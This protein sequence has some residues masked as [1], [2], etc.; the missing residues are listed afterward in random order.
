MEKCVICI[1]EKNMR[2]GS[3]QRKKD[4]E[5]KRKKEEIFKTIYDSKNNL[6]YISSDQAMNVYTFLKIT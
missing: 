1:S 3:R 4:R 2:D 5:R 6:R